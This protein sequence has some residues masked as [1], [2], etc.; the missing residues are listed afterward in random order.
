MTSP[1]RRGDASTKLVDN[2]PRAQTGR[3]IGFQCPETFQVRGQKPD[4]IDAT[5]RHMTGKLHILKASRGNT[6]VTR[7]AFYM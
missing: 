2:L 6:A 4:D 5:G 7:L 3:P 1:F